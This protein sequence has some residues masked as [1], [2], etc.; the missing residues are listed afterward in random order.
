VCL[1]AGDVNE[2]EDV[3]ALQPGRFNREQVG[4]EHLGGVLTDELAPGGL[5]APRSRRDALAAQ[6]LGHSHVRD[7]EAQLECLAL[8]ALV[9]PARVLFR[10]LEDQRPPLGVAGG[11]L[12]RRALPKGR[13]LCRTKSRCQRSKVSGFGSRADQADLGRSWLKAANRMR[14]PGCQAGL[15]TLRSKTRS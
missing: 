12:P 9:A 14:S 1:A 8:D 10:E 7:L 6:D 3:E 15:P 4:G 5:A 2:E 11:T 13:P